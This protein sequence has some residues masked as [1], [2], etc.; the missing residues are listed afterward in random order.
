[1]KYIVHSSNNSIFPSRI[2]YLLD[3]QNDNFLLNQN[4]TYIDN[5]HNYQ[6]RIYYDYRIPCTQFRLTN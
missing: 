5:I 1:M 2:Q 4:V 3:Y 6:L